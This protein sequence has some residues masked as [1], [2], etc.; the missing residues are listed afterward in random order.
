MAPGFPL[1]AAGAPAA[2]G[3]AVDRGTTRIPFSPI[4]IAPWGTIALFLASFTSFGTTAKSRFDFN[5]L[6]FSHFTVTSPARSLLNLISVPVEFSSCPV[7]LSSFF[8]VSSSLISGSF[9]AAGFVGFLAV[10]CASPERA[11][12]NK[13]DRVTARVCRFRPNG[14]KRPSKKARKEGHGVVRDIRDYRERQAGK[15][16]AKLSVQYKRTDKLGF[17][18]RRTSILQTDSVGSLVVRVGDV[19]TQHRRLAA[20]HK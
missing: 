7:N 15:E 19:L 13:S 5:S 10:L 1:A 4:F 3:L 17:S 18:I 9:F 6:T 16:L 12:T 2:S 11:V 20:C 14:R 8:R